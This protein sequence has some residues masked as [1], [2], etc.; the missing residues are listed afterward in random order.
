MFSI[1]TS[2]LIK[3]HIRIRIL[4]LTIKEPESYI[5]CKFKLCVNGLT[6]TTYYNN[7]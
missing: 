7:F 4:F 3:L 5:H 6:D 2:Y 1:I